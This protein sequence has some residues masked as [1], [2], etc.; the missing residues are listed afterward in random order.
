MRRVT[1]A[2]A[3]YRANYHRKVMG[4]AFGR[5]FGQ[6]ILPHTCDNIVDPMHFIPK[7]LLRNEAKTRNYTDQETWELVWDARNGAPGCRWFHTS[8]DT[9]GIKKIVIPQSRLPRA[10]IDFCYDNGVV[11]ALD[12]LYPKEGDES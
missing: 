10:V 12:R 8:L 3:K 2:E 9:P 11:W 5:C 4:L 6:T 1:P 7:Q